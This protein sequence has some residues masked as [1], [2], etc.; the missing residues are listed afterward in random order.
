[1][2]CTAVT[3]AGLAHLRGIRKLGLS[4]CTAIT[5]TGLAHL[6]GIHKLAMEGFTLVTDAG[7]AHLNG[8]HTLYMW[9]C[10]GITNVGMIHLRGIRVL[11]I[12]APKS[13]RQPWTSWRAPTSSEAR[14]RRGGLGAPVREEPVGGIVVRGGRGALSLLQILHDS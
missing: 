12:R 13:P 7:L 10:P 8:I 3:D 1:M 4:G 2:G 6:R 11:H 14:G 9:R 5:D